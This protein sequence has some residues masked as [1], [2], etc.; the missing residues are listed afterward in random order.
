MYIN[1]GASV[2]GA[3]RERKHRPSCSCPVRGGSATKETLGPSVAVLLACLVGRL[4]LPRGEMVQPVALPKSPGRLRVKRR[5][6]VVLRAQGKWA[7]L[8]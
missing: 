3:H 6:V 1:P 7:D 8:P 5:R 4:A 2:S